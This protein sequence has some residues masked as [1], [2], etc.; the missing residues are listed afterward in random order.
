LDRRLG[1]IPAGW[2]KM[3]IH[4]LAALAPRKPGSQSIAADLVIRALAI[5]LVVTQHATI[6]PIPGGSAAMVVLIGYNLARFQR[7]ALMAGDFGRFLKPVISVLGPYY[8]ILAAY[9]VSWD[10]LPWASVALVGNLGIADPERHTM[11]PFL[12]WFVEAFVQI[13]AVWALLF[14]IPPV[15]RLTSRD[16]F[17]FGALFLAGAVAFRFTIPLVWSM[18]GREI[19]SLYWVLYLAVLGW[20]VAFAE[21]REKRAVLLVA[22]AA[23]LLASAYFG[24]NWTGSWVR[25]S[26][27]FA[28][29]CV[30]LYLPAMR[31]PSRLAS[32]ILPVAVASYHIYLFHRFVPELLLAGL[33]TRI[34]PALFTLLAIVGG[35]AIGIAVQRLQLATMQ[36]IS[37][38]AQ[39]KPLRQPAEA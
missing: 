21:T 14:A 3:P 26:M 25:Y 4:A 13:M 23:I 7:D 22:S 32:A 38:L 36:A 24:G 28:V 2:E 27:Q 19:F 39:Q 10:K 9:A 29:I 18:G 30:L 35:V 11:L 6:W 1:F 15:R 37:R 31:L 17:L 34:P 12:Y 20:C 8:L 16:P 5:L 33:E